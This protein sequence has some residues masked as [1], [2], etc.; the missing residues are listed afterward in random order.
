M[1][2]LG[3][4]TPSGLLAGLITALVITGIA[5]AQGG[6]LFNPGPLNAQEGPALGGVTSHAMIGE[7]CKACQSRP[8][9]GKAWMTAVC[10]AIR[11]LQSKK[12]IRRA[13]MVQ[14]INAIPKLPAAHVTPNIKGHRH[15]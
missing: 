9:S 6:M 3:C 14:F 13:Y 4:L 10:N 12:Q 7:E 1:K 5:V 2:R 15:H 11:L 8:G